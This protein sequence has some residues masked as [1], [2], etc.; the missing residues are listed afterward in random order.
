MYLSKYYKYKKSKWKKLHIA[1][2]TLLLVAM[3]PNIT[4][5]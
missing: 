3:L 4:S 1:M 2:W 5:A